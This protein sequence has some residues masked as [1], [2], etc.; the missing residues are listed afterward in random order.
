MG[1]SHELIEE[2]TAVSEEVAK[3]MVRGAIKALNVDYA[4]AATGFAGRRLRGGR[5]V[6]Q[7]KE[8]TDSSQIGAV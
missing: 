8:R 5:K 1:V 6:K 2:K 7:L 3:E 4:I